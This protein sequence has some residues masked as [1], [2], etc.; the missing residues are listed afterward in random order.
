[1]THEIRRAQIAHLSPIEQLLNTVL[2]ETE[3]ELGKN[4]LSDRNTQAMKALRDLHSVASEIYETSVFPF[5]RRVASVLTIGYA[6]QVLTLVKEV[7][8]KFK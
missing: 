1:V 8:S 5:N 3:N 6:L 2:G 4:K 7:A